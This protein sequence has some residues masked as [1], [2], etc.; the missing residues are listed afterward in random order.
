MRQ[1]LT[2]IFLFFF[3]P[4]ILAQVEI[5]GFI[6]DKRSGEPI[7]P[8]VIYEQGTNNYAFSNRYGF[9][10]LKISSGRH[11]LIISALGYLPDTM[12][13]NLRWDTV[14]NINLQNINTLEAV[15]VSGDYSPL[16]AEYTGIEKLSMKQIKLI[17]A[18]AGETDLSKAF[19]L[20]P[21]VLQGN[22]GSSNLLVRGGSADQ[23]L[24]IL[25]DVPLYYVNHLGGFIS[26]FNSDAINDATL[27]KGTYPARYG[28]RLSSVFD[29]NMK[30]GNIK[31]FSG[32]FTSGLLISK[33]TLEF[34]VI[35]NKSSALFSVRTSPVGLMMLPITYLGWQKQAYFY[36]G[37]YDLNAKL[38]WR[39][40]NKN[41]I[42]LSFYNGD[43]P[44]TYGLPSEKNDFKLTYKQKWGNTLTALRWNHIYGKKMFSNLT[45]YYTRFR[46]KLGY[47][48]FSVGTKDSLSF[49]TFSGI[50]DWAV[51]D[52]FTLSLNRN[53][54]M[55]FGFNSVFHNFRPLVS[56]YKYY[57]STNA[58]RVDTI[59]IDNKLSSFETDFYVEN[60]F[61][62]KKFKADLGLRTSVF[63]IFNQNITYV[64]PEPR[65][66][67]N[68]LMNNDLSVKMSYASTV[69]FL[70]L[71]SGIGT[72]GF[73]MD[74]WLPAD[75]LLP[76]ENARQWA[77]GI[78]FKSKSF[79]V[80]VETFYKTM[81][82]LISFA[83]GANILSSINNWKSS[84]E[85]EGHGW[86]YGTEILVKK[87]SGK[88][89]GWLS[90]AYTRSW[91]KFQNINLGKPFPYKYD[92]PIDISLV[93]IHKLK[94]GVVLSAVW[95]YGTGYPY[96]KPIGIVPLIDNLS[97]TNF[98]NN[99]IW[100]PRNSSRMQDY[101]R[102]DIALKFV[103]QKKHSKR[104]WTI[105][106]YN[107]YNRKNAYFYD[108]GGLYD[109]GTKKFKYRI[110]K[111]TLFPIIP[112]VSYSLT[113]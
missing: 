110:E 21:G 45:L 70:H 9:Y 22:E 6:Q 92:R 80:S 113:F 17:P 94:P 96:T 76:P 38:H 13:I 109:P 30:N 81:D 61:S 71:L 68:Y 48:Y 37:F 103:K 26:N 23:T 88:T 72:T 85:K 102:L 95:T 46:Y 36:Y 107:A 104:T 29:V 63:H 5:K 86:A 28:G 87:I 54:L 75:T 18:L 24:V 111:F 44:L 101:H 57:L 90:V 15:V 99:F 8:A 83:E 12:L 31:N 20:L 16:R 65:L 7:Q 4:R 112:S 55:R 11:K 74:L 64:F 50:N 14:I 32:T 89:T 53:Y 78:Y 66:T 40:D 77:A 60:H 33:L 10:L 25:D 41:R 39:L 52:D 1:Y 84:V 49:L 69:R 93:L 47:D 56:H 42:Y 2:I 62:W 100:E 106:I 108:I 3:L 19:Q 105:S 82:N 27:Y 43:D 34:P 58:A 79:Q 73:P 98:Y 97:G 51:K 59:L 91:R 67:I 35:K